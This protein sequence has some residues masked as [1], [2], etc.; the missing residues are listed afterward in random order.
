MDIEQ[1]KAA[2]EQH[3]ISVGGLFVHEQYGNP[4]IRSGRTTPRMRLAVGSG[5]ARCWTCPVTEH[6]RTKIMH[7]TSCTEEP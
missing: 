5:G 3:L 2:H 6:F 4:I 7:Q 1:M